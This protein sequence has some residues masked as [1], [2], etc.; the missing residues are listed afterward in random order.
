MK[1]PGL[2]AGDCARSTDSIRTRL[3]HRLQNSSRDKIVLTAP[4][5]KWY[6]LKNIMKNGTLRLCTGFTLV[7]V[8]L[9]SI[10]LTGLTCLRDFG[11]L[12][13]PGSATTSNDAI[14]G[15]APSSPMGGESLPPFQNVSN[16]SCPCHHVTHLSNLPMLSAFYTGGYVLQNLSSVTDNPPQVIFRPP[17]A[18]S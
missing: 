6:F 15:S 14:C 2:T 3:Q 8:F 7:L 11:G 9:L 1:N 16:H 13:S 18:L 10:Q 5:M 12:L 17:I 4:R